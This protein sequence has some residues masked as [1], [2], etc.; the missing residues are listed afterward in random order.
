M[1]P[2][3]LYLDK[4]EQAPDP[5]RVNPVEGDRTARPNELKECDQFSLRVTIKTNLLA[6]LAVI[7]KDSRITAEIACAFAKLPLNTIKLSREV[8]AKT[9]DV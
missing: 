8:S 4:E 5:G 9:R 6:E 3:P 2:C 7:G 1:T